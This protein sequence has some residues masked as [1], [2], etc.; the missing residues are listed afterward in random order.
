MFVTET[1]NINGKVYIRVYHKSSISFLYEIVDKPVTYKQF[2]KTGKCAREQVE[3]FFKMEMS[4][5]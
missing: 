4:D 2:Q 3:E 1:T 5:G